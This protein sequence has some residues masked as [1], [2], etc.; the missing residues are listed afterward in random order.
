MV[1]SG[2]GLGFSLISHGR[3]PSQAQLIQNHVKVDY[4]PKKCF[5]V[6]LFWVFP[7]HATTGLPGN[8]Y[9]V[10]RRLN[11]ETK[12][13]QGVFRCLLNFHLS[14]MI[15]SCSVCAKTDNRFF[16]ISQ[17][18]VCN[19]LLQWGWDSRVE[20]KKNLIYTFFY[21]NNFYKNIEAE[22]CPKI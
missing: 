21:K 11:L 8:V 3:K 20:V 15:T 2:W 9:V 7:S 22:I 18:R 17:D 16:S 14:F 12:G 19:F 1:W 4:F 13:G 5:D 6:S 10:V